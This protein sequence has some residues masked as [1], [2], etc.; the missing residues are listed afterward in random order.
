[1]LKGHCKHVSR[2]KIPLIYWKLKTYCWKHC[3]KI[4]LKCV[5]SVMGPKILW[6]VRCCVFGCMVNNAVGP[7][8]KPKCW[9]RTLAITKRTLKV[10]KGVSLSHGRENIIKSNIEKSAFTWGAK[11]ESLLFLPCLTIVEVDLNWH[12][13]DHFIRQLLYGFV[14]RKSVV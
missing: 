14:D 9:K 7:S 3:N 11:R 12:Y 5:N 1:M 13:Q 2:V 6:Y 4:I 10:V 8:Q